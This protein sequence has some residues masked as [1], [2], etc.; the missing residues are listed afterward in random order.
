M[1]LELETLYCQ[2]PNSTVQ[3]FLLYN[4]TSLKSAVKGLGGVHYRK[5]AVHSGEV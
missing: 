1:Y 2:D 4:E 3:P 5:L